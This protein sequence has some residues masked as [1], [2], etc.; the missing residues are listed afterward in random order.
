M[1]KWTNTTDT[2]EGIQK[3][4]AEGKRIAAAKPVVYSENMEVE[5]FRWP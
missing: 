2:Y 5:G 4:C 1:D 3:H